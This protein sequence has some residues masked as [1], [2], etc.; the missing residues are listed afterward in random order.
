MHKKRS[1]LIIPYESLDIIIEFI[2]NRFSHLHNY[3]VNI[4]IENAF[5]NYKLNSRILRI[6]NFFTLIIMMYA[7]YFIVETAKGIQIALGNSLL[8][9]IIGFSILLPIAL[10][11]YQRKL[12]KE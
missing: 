3:M 11:I 5:K 6:I 2:V 12:N 7:A 1:I 10:F 4:T 9:I 8:P